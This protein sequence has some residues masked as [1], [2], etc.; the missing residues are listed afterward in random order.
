MAVIG[1]A[2][3]YPPYKGGGHPAYE[4]IYLYQNGA[5]NDNCDFENEEDWLQW[6]Y[7]AVDPAFCGFFG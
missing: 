6:S 3:A 5:E 7:L 2:Q 4:T 1:A